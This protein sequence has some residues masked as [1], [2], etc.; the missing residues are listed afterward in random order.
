MAC[1]RCGLTGIRPQI[2]AYH[3]WH[4]VYSLCLFTPIAA[5]C[6]RFVLHIGIGKGRQSGSRP[7]PAERLQ[8]AWKAVRMLRR[9]VR[10]PRSAFGF[11]G[12]ASRRLEG[13]W[14]PDGWFRDVSERVGILPSRFETSRRA[15]GFC[16]FVSRRL[17]VGWYFHRS[18]RD[19]SEGTEIPPGGFE[20]HGRLC[21]WR[22]CWKMSKNSH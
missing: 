13:G 16:R 10:T 7:S 14:N 22:G 12:V 9:S 4:F 2:A 18:F 6:K 8:R 21:K 15:L 17:E 3:G 5:S 19:V 20:T 11:H 1:A